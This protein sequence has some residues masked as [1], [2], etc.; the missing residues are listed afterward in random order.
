MHS[1]RARLALSMIAAA[2]LTTAPLTPAFAD[3]KFDLNDIGTV[4]RG[5]KDVELSADVDDSDLYCRIKIKFADGFVFTADK[6]QA[7]KKG[8]CKVKINMPDWRAAVG[9]A[10]AKLQVVTKK[11]EERGNASRNFYVRDRR[12]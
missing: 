2:L 1:L 7:D 4:K 9:L 12:G 6:V 5:D 11:D 10:T 3:D 8:K